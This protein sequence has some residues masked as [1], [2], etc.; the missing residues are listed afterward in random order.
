MSAPV[1]FVGDVSLILQVV[2]LFILILGVPLVKG[3]SK[4]PKNFLI[5]GYLT[6]LALGLHT[7]L[8]AVIMI[9]LAQ[10]GLVGMFTLPLLNI[11]VSLSHIVLGFVALALGF[12]VVG[13]WLNKPLKSMACY[14]VRTLMMPLII[15]WAVSLVLGAVMHLGGL[16]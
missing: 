7:V 5:H 1:D 8:V 14:R 10:D 3:E 13:Y 11:V 6:A 2:I 15:I 12:I 16:F 9:F 4:N